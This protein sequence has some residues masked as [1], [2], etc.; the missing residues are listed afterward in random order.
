MENE[1]ECPICQKENQKVLSKFNRSEKQLS[2]QAFSQQLSRASDGFST[3]IDMLSRGEISLYQPK[4]VEPEEPDEFAFETR[5]SPRPVASN[6][7]L[8]NRAKIAAK[9]KSQVKNIWKKVFYYVVI[10]MK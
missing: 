4:K 3:M 2:E 5:E 1:K 7:L 6:K 9:L 8:A 10:G